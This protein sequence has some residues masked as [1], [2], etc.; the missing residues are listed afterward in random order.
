MVYYSQ[1]KELNKN[2]PKP[3]LRLCKSKNGYVLEK[4]HLKISKEGVEEEN[5]HE[6]EESPVL[7]L[8]GNAVVLISVP[9]L[10]SVHIE[11]SSITTEYVYPFKEYFFCRR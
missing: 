1:N 11:S 6:G 3:W 8:E 2:L 10:I 7:S 9:N 5:C 4:A